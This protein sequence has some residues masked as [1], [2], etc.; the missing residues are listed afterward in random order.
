MKDILFTCNLGNYD[1]TPKLS[2]TLNKSWWK[3]LFTDEEGVHNSFDQVIYL[4][5][6]DRPDLLS[7]EV[8]WNVNKWLEDANLF[9]WFDSNMTII[10]NIPKHP[11][12]IIHPRRK[13]VKQEV[14]ACNAQLHRCT[15]ETLNRQYEYFISNGFKD[16]YGLFLNGFHCRRNSKIDNKISEQV[17]EVLN[18]F[19]PR[20]QVAFPYVLSKLGH[21]YQKNE[22]M[23]VIY[24]NRFIKMSLH[25]EKSPPLYV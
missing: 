25:Q 9:C 4:P 8:K 23:S 12:R 13:T 10:N 3:V 17:V 19:S 5:K 18:K 15:K 20:D 2:R 11:F 14:D 16:D 22:L 7:K 1:N 24:F 6:T 21:A